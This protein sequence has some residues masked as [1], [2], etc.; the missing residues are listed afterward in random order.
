MFV[1]GREDRLTGNP[2]ALVSLW[3]TQMQCQVLM[4][5]LAK[6][7]CQKKSNNKTKIKLSLLL[8]CCF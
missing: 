8:F 6:N 5:V 4:V 3:T 1:V 7:N 2:I